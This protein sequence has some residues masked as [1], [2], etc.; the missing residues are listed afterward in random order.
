MVA[1][2]KLQGV[3]MSPDAPM[4]LPT[5]VDVLDYKPAMEIIALHAPIG[6]LPTS[7]PGGRTCEREARRL[8]GFQRGGAVQSAPSR[9][10]V[11]EEDPAKLLELGLSAVALVQLPRIR[12]LAAQAQPYWQRT[13]YE[14]HPETSFYQL[15]RDQP[16]S[17]PKRSEPGLE[18]RRRLLESKLAGVARILDGRTRGA[19]RRHRM[20]AAVC[21]YTA[22]RIAARAIT[23][24]PVDPE[25][26]EEGLRMEI[27]R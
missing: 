18:Q 25:W 13:V 11:A 5:I 7:R 21:L 2:A 6:L 9:E 24:I 3:T 20:D 1:S 26:D 19:S 23:R 17:Y 15:N 10:A 22:R 27:V 16:L 4:V 12:E 14:V 8:L